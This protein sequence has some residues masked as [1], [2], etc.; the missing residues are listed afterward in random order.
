MLP[1]SVNE[2]NNQ[3][4]NNKKKKIRRK[5]KDIPKKYKVNFDYNISVVFLLVVNF[6]V[7]DHQQRII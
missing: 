1:I 7:Q 2:I 5:A 4:I 3:T 6:M